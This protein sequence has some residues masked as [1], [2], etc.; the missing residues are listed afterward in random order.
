MNK[1]ALLIDHSSSCGG[2]Q[3]S[4]MTFLKLQHGF[5]FILI[6]HFENHRLI[7]FCIHNN[8]RFY[9]FNFQKSVFVKFFRLMCLVK[10]IRKNNKVSFIYGNTFE[11]GFWCAI[12]K[13]FYKI[14]FVFRARLA[15]NRF[16]HGIVDF[17]IYNFA[18]VIIANSNFVKSSFLERF[19]KKE[20]EKIIVIYN[21]VVSDFNKLSRRS[22]NLISKDI[23][24]VAIIGTIEVNKGHL[25]AIK[26]IEFLK[27]ILN[28]HNVRLLVIGSPDKNDNGMYYN[29]I[30][31]YALKAKLTS[32]NLQFIGYINHPEEIYNEI[33]LVI[34]CH[35]FEALSRV[36]FETQLFGIPNVAA[37]SGGNIELITNFKTGLLFEANNYSDL[38]D[39][40]SVI[41]SD[42]ILY[43]LISEKSNIQTIDYFSKQNTIEKEMYI[44]NKL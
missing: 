7:D 20:A 41:L 15:I 4:L 27:N 36:M 17:I 6:L 5:N 37:N 23:Y 32:D 24:N 26:A 39:K 33:D 14:P 31:D 1:D 28:I 13:I 18:D 9:K 38:A 11:G 42:K 44:L 40:I 30:K 35:Q 22:R 19:G 25:I 8:I 16:N 2:G 29:K 10:S 12:L 3:I 43:E 34:N 21:P